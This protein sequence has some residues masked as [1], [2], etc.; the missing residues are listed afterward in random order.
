MCLEEIIINPLCGRVKRK[1]V[2]EDYC[3][4]FFIPHTSVGV[5]LSLGECCSTDVTRM[6]S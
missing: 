5:G 3:L 6:Y 2:L 4:W 1:E